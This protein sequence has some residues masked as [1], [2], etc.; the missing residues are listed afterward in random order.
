M[1]KL[2]NLNVILIFSILFLNDTT[3]LKCFRCSSDATNFKFCEDILDFSQM[4]EQQKLWNYVECDAAPPPHY[5]DENSGNLIAKCRIILQHVN[6]VPTYSRSCI[7]EPLNVPANSCAVQNVSL[8][9][10]KTISCNT[11]TADGCNDRLL[12]VPATEPDKIKNSAA[13]ISVLSNAL[14]AILLL[15]VVIRR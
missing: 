8:P 4:T 9:Y 11:C 14:F 15:S 13:T 6:D 12:N 1:I 3:A 5:P 7:W 10:V 2:I